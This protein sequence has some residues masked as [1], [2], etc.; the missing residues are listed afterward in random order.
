MILDNLDVEEVFGQLTYKMSKNLTTY[1]R[2]GT[3]EEKYDNATG[4]KEKFSDQNRG[5][6]Q[7]EYTF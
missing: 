3:Y 6:I 5:R 4:S 2:Y 7:V 1:L